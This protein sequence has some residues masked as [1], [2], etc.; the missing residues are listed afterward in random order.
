MRTNLVLATL[1]LLLAAP[2][3]Q[4]PDEGEEEPFPP[5][6]S[7]HTEKDFSELL[8][9]M[10]GCWQLIDLELPEAETA[11]RQEIAFVL[12][13][14]EFLSIEFHLGYFDEEDF[15]EESYFQSGTYRLAMDDRGLLVTSTLIG[16][17]FDDEERLI[18][19]PP[20]FRRLFSAQVDGESLKLVRFEDGARFVFEKLASLG[21]NDFYGRPTP[22]K[23]K[24]AGK[25]TEEEPEKPPRKRPR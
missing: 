25:G 16:S 3:A 2:F 8:E 18:F 11:S 19:E 13:S 5:E 4:D 22:R 21:G 17:V 20:G 24:P 15:L 14:Q 1:S 23:E 12:V 9:A 7:R 6:I 10:Q